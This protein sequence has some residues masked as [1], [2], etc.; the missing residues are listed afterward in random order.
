MNGWAEV[1]RKYYLELSKEEVIFIR[2]SMQNSPFGDESDTELKL[3]TALLNT[4]KNM[5]EEK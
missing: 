5:L 1:T 2:D 4:T 3:R